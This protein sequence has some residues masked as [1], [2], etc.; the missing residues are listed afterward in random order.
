MAVLSYMSSNNVTGVRGNHDQKVIEWRTWLEWIKG[1][2][3]GREWLDDVHKR[4]AQAESQ[5]EDLDE[6]VAREKARSKSPW[7]QRVPEGWEI[8]SDHYN[9]ARAMSKGQYAYLL[10]L[11]LTLHIPSTHTFIVHAGLL[12]SDPRHKPSSHKQPLAR[13]PVLPNSNGHTNSS[14]PVLRR[15]QEEAL[16]NQI[17]QNADPWTVLNMRGVL[18]KAVVRTK[19]GTPWSD[20]WNS[21]MSHCSGF[22]GQ[23]TT[24]KKHKNALPCHPSTVLY[25]HAA[26]RGLDVKRWSIGL[27]SGCVSLFGP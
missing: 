10:S 26:S 23:L 4:W 8:F 22:D 11:P 14:T 12:P 18:H 7:W 13:V 6:W 16:L 9:I 19:D 17:P 1:F 3:G 2:P 5:G 25:G 20:I 21:Q 24:G 27:D 15:L